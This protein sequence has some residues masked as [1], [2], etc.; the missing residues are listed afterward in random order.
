MTFSLVELRFRLTN[1][2]VGFMF[3]LQK[4]AVYLHGTF[5][6][7]ESKE[8]GIIEANLHAKNDT[9]SHHTWELIEYSYAFDEDTVYSTRKSDQS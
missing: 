6:I 5:W 9:D 7:G 3:Y 8:Q 4:S 2:R 1:E